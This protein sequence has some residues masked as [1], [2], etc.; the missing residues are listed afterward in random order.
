[1]P[2]YE[3]ICWDKKKFNI[4]EVAF[5]KKACEYKKWAFAADY[6]RLYALYHHGGIYLDSDVR[7]F[8]S[9]DPFLG[10]A[11]FSS[12]EFHPEMFYCSLKKGSYA[13]LGIEAAV[14]GSEK[15]HPWI[16]CLMD[17]YKDKEFI[18]KPNY[19]LKFI[20]S[21]VIAKISEEFGFV[22]YPVYQVL[23]HDVHLYP[24]DV[25]SR[26]GLESIVK[27]SSHLCASSWREPKQR[28]MIV[29]SVRKSAKSI[30]NFLK[31]K[32]F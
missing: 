28:S 5:V 10:H 19:Y 13:G 25:F 16:K 26:N 18:N 31:L 2:D 11:A 8:R 27:Y 32:P 22:Y 4:E 3:I 29:R 23:K 9:F 1:M 24:P 20:M 7:V 6:I 15:H 17:Y 21:G 30:L 12:V 14:L